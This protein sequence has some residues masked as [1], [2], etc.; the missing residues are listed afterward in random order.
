MFYS[1]SRVAPLLFYVLAA[2]G[3]RVAV[4]ERQPGL[5]P[6]RRT[7]IVTPELTEVI[8][9]LP[10]PKVL[11]ENSVMRK[12]LAL[13]FDVVIIGAGSSYSEFGFTVIN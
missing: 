11:N 5:Q 2:N 13:F 10:V 1:F 3:K 4:F 6:A 9:D 8:E 12:G 7:D